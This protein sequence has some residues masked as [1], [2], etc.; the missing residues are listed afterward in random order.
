MALI[1]RLCFFEHSYEDRAVVD[2]VLV[3]SIAIRM[4]NSQC[5]ELNEEGKCDFE[6]E[7][8]TFEVE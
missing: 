2:A 4:Q 3:I 1:A 7:H 6:V 8:I 5:A